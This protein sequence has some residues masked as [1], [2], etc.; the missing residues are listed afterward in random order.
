MYKN[1]L[2]MPEKHKKITALCLRPIIPGFCN[3]KSKFIRIGLRICRQSP[4]DG[5]GSV[6]QLGGFNL[7]GTAWQNVWEKNSNYRCN[8]V[9][10][11]NLYY[12]LFIGNV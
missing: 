3:V 10:P 9:N 12:P 8:G 1:D 6:C 11:T 7:N 5:D 4:L 2:K